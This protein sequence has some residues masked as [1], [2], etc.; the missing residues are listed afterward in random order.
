MANGHVTY[1]IV[2]AGRAAASAAAAI[3]ERDP[4]SALLMVGQEQH[5]PYD[6]V[7]LSKEY[8]RRSMARDELT[9]LPMGWFKENNVELRTRTRVALLEV[10]RQRA[11]LASG[12]EVS[13]EKLLLATG[14]SAVP[15]EVPGAQL[16]DVF[17]LRTIDD[18]SLLHHAIETFARIPHHTP[19]AV[20]VGGGE[21]GIETAASL[22]ELGVK[23][24]LV[25]RETH[26]WSRYAGEAVGRWLGETLRQRGVNVHL[27]QPVKQLLGDGRVQRVE[28]AFGHTIDTDLLVACVGMTPNLQLLRGTP[29]EA[30]RGV[31]VDAGCRTSVP[32]VLAAGDCCML[33]DPLFGKYRMLEHWEEAHHQGRIAGENMAGGQATYDRV[34]HFTSRFFSHEVHQWG[35]VRFVDR[36]VV[37]GEVR[38]DA[39]S[40]AEFGLDAQG[41]VVQVI[42]LNRD[43]EYPA[44]EATLRQKRT[45][46]GEEDALRDVTKP[47]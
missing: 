36:R 38:V 47:L 33:L 35:D 45:F 24:D 15:L 12:D 5:R 23:V 22:T 17:T 32:N 39:P 6:R 14:G 43:A 1:L 42:A 13:Y 21:L 19:R 30:Q 10:G 29:I 28:L 46:A 20:V 9:V 27:G 18:V 37:R 25:V 7:A 44:Y 8:L 41:R 40:F 16:P 3:R 2:G 31:M 26:C 11:T 4:A 34:S